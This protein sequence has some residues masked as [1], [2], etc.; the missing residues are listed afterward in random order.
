VRAGTLEVELGGA[1]HR[2]DFSHGM[3]VIVAVSSALL[4]DVVN[5]S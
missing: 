5:H 2:F 4:V 1:I 3:W